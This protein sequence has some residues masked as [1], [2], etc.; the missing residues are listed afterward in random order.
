MKRLKLNRSC[1]VRK[2]LLLGSL[3]LAAGMAHSLSAQITTGSLLDELG[4]RDRLAI[5]PSGHYTQE[6]ASSHDTRNGL[7][8]SRLGAPWGSVNVDFGN[9]I[10]SMEVDGR[11]ELVLMEEKGPGVV[12][13]W[14]ATGINQG[15]LERHRFRIYLDGAE[16]PTI[17]ATA[18]ELVGGNNL[19]FGDA[20]NYR[21]PKLGGNNYAPI[22]YKSGIIITWD[23]P[24]THGHPHVA[25][26]DPN[27]RNSVENALWYNINFRKLPPGTDVISY[28]DE[29]KKKYQRNFKQTGR[30]LGTDTPTGH[31]AKRFS[32]KRAIADGASMSHK[33]DGTGAIR[34]IRLKV[35][36]DDQVA[37]LAKS[38][39]VLVFD[40]QTTAR[41][42]AGQFFWQWA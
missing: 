10:R 3:W 5:Y 1:K 24:M 14:W 9:Y 13:R 26:R 15:L 19:G 35:S 16:E 30:N 4:D 38:H 31:V 22:A 7:G 27:L 28:S 29:E 8:Y 32:D 18:S 25:L 42:P 6:Q 40:G 36:G 34:R 11:T 12:T 39:I 21:T 20:L 2:A 41:V 23:G 17:T 37:A 33:I